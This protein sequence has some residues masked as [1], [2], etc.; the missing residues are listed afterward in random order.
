MSA[1]YVILYPGQCCPGYCVD[2]LLHDLRRDQA[3]RLVE[4]LPEVAA[5]AWDEGEAHESQHLAVFGQFCPHGSRCNPYRAYALA[6]T[7]NEGG[8]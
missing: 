7:D 5:K 2:D 6:P 4:V 3:D 1:E 8:Q